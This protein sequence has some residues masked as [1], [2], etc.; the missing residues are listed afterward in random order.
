MSDNIP[1][2]QSKGSNK[3]IE[4][5]ALQLLSARDSQDV[6]DLRGDTEQRE[7]QKILPGNETEKKLLSVLTH[8]PSHMD[9]ICDLTGLSLEKDSAPLVLMEFKGRV[10]QVG[11][12]NYVAVR[13]EQA[14]YK[15]KA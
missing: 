6:L 8:E 7:V 15:V 9:N 12:I 5:G 10:R 3:L 1:A 14:E 11:G 2:S 13:K 4:E